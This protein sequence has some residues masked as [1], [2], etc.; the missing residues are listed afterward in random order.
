MSVMVTAQWIAS[1]TYVEQFISVATAYANSMKAQ[2]VIFKLKDGRRKYAT[3]NGA[4]LWWEQYDLDSL[5]R[6]IEVI[7]MPAFTADFQRFDF[8]YNALRE[9]YPKARI[10]RVA[11]YEIEDVYSP[12]NPDV[13]Y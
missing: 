2:R 13:I 5:A 1:R 6:N 4:I 11:G 12:I 3:H 10:V 9:R 8:D 7:G